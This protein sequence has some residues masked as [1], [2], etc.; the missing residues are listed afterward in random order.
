MAIEGKIRLFLSILIYREDSWWI[1][2]CLEMD[3][4]AEGHT[5][6][7]ALENLFDIAKLQIQTAIEED[8]LQSIFSPAPA[9]LWKLFAE[10]RDFPDRPARVP[11]LGV[12][13]LH[14]RE[15][16]PVGV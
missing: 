5:A 12:D 1:A 10:S 2:H 11:I 4:P 15:L 6:Q 16:I 13:R 14:I 8:D 3:L 9:E 7:G